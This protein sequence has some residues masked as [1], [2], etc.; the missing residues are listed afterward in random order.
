MSSA[1]KDA[2][3]ASFSAALRVARNGEPFPTT[4][5][6]LAGAALAGTDSIE[7]AIKLA[8]MAR[9]YLIQVR[10]EREDEELLKRKVS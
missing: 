2:L 10:L 6:S 1:V 4:S 7:S 5:A 9:T 3:L 8:D